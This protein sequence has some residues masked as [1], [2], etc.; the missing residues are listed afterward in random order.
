[1]A[2]RKFSAITDLDNSTRTLV[3]DF[4]GLIFNV[5]VYNDNANA[6]NFHLFIDG[7]NTLYKQQIQPQETLQ[8]KPEIRLDIETLKFYGELSGLHVIVQILQD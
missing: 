1:M 7:G 5:L 4:R 6:N 3:T 2:L 8:F